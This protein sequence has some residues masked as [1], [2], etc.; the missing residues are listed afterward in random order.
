MEQNDRNEYQRIGGYHFV[1]ISAL[2]IERLL[3][4]NVYDK[5]CCLM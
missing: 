1:D 2:T 5:F 4:K 3:G